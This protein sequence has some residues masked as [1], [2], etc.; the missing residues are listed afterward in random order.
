MK[1]KKILTTM[2]AFAAAATVLCAA[3]L[4]T[5]LPSTLTTPSGT[6]MPDNATASAVTASDASH[7]VYSRISTAELVR[8]YLREPGDM[9]WI[10]VIDAQMVEYHSAEVARLEC[11][12]EDSI[13]YID[14]DTGI[15]SSYC[16]LCGVNGVLA[17]VPATATVTNAAKRA[18]CSH[19]YTDWL[20]Y[21]SD[22][23]KKICSK[24][25]NVVYEAHTKIPA[26]CT[27]FEHCGV[28]NGRDS[29]W[30]YA[31]GHDMAYR[32]DWDYLDSHGYDNDDNY[33]HV[34]RC[35]RDD[36]CD[37]IQT[38]E[39]CNF[40]ELFW[41]AESGGEHELYY[42][43]PTCYVAFYWEPEICYFAT[44]GFD[45]YRCNNPHP[46]YY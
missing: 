19:E 20:F 40:N 9:E 1:T 42:Q 32:V 22:F 33:Y 14:T 25:M 13:A 36:I 24:C 18:T 21:N 8:K 15:S 27:T 37:Y 23:H 30:M 12:H 35:I 44:H 43:C 17:E 7:K 45:C 2:A 39:K 31:Y 4:A 41:D 26:D 11:T 3:V 34:Y 6:Q 28:C 5:S 10:R 38:R 29:S 16:T 46:G